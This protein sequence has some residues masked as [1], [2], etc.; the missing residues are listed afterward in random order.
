MIAHSEKAKKFVYTSF[1]ITASGYI[2]PVLA[3]ATTNVT[4]YPDIF[5]YSL[6][7]LLICT[8]ISIALNL[9]IEKY[10]FQLRRLKKESASK[11]R[12]RFINTNKDLISVHTITEYLNMTN[13]VMAAIGFYVV[14]FLHQY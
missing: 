2:C 14:A 7:V 3:I 4:E 11:F 1:A 8:V 13:I 5:Y 12:T 9:F 6:P 10:I